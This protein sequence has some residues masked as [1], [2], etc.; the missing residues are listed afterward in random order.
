MRPR[1]YYNIYIYIYI[2]QLIGELLASILKCYI[3]K[4]LP[5]RTIDILTVKL[6]NSTLH[7]SLYLSYEHICTYIIAVSAAKLAT[8]LE[9]FIFKLLPLQ[10]IDYLTLT[11]SKSTPQ[12][13]VYLISELRH[14]YFSVF[15]AI[16]AAI[17]D[18]YTFKLL[19]L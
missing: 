3:T 13:S 17:L 1:K 16:L 12:L 8:I 7:L 9:R 11:L 10:E 14:T 5:L 19:Q 18:S 4:L 15:T 2:Y 6:F